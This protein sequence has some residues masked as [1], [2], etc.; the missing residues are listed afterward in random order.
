MTCWLLQRLSRADEDSCRGKGGHQRTLCAGD[1][2][3]VNWH[4]RTLRTE[5]RASLL[6]TRML[7]VAPGTATRSILTSTDF[8]VI[9]SFWTFWGVESSDV[10]DTIQESSNSNGSR[11]PNGSKWRIHSRGDGQGGLKPPGRPYGVE[12]MA[13]STSVSIDPGLEHGLPLRILRCLILWALHI[14][15]D[16]PELELQALRWCTRTPAVP[17]IASVPL[18]GM[19]QTCLGP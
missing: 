8:W 14:E 10:L 13:S 12:S 15:H 11:I 3:A 1:T 9:W 5:Q 4:N 18:I 19:A 16:H 2:S 6:V 7:L 17:A